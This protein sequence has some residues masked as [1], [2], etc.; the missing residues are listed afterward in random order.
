MRR[1][2]YTPS[3]HPLRQCPSLCGV[4]SY[5]PLHR[6][7]PASPPP[8]Y[9]LMHTV[10]KR[11]PPQAARSVPSPVR[12][13]VES[14]SS[15]QA[16]SLSPTAKQ[17]LGAQIPDG[18]R[19]QPSL[20]ANKGADDGAEAF[21]QELWGGSCGSSRVSRRR[22][23]AKRLIFVSGSVVDQCSTASPASIVYV[24][25]RFEYPYPESQAGE[26]PLCL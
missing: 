26:S 13:N 15:A 17:I 7:P 5:H 25:L 8:Q 3:Y 6:R 1:Q 21:G 4:S 16:S 20:Q 11:L 18:R 19:K 10:R 9:E 22:N 14:E 24:V 23:R 12:H 2:A